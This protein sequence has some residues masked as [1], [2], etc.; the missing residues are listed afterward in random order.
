MSAV[1]PNN[2]DR[3]V[4]ALEKNGKSGIEKLLGQPENPNVK[5]FFIAI[6]EAQTCMC[7]PLF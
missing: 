4:S 3:I 2:F 7:R 1:I 5:D 6:D